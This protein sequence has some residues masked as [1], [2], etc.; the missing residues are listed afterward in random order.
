VLFVA[1]CAV[2]VL[3]AA[4]PVPAAPALPRPAHVV[5]IIEENHTEAS[6]IGNADARYMNALAHQGALF[7]RSYAITHPSLPNYLALFSGR[8]NDNGDG[9]PATGLPHTAPSLGGELTAAGL[10]FTGYAEGLPAPGSMVCWAGNYAR[11]HAPWVH[12]TDIAQAQQSL[13]LTRFPQNFERLP[14]LA[15]LIPDQM[16]DMHDGTIAQAD[17]WLRK[18]VAPLVTWAQTHDTLVILTWDE[19][20]R[21]ADNR[22]PTIFLGSMVKPGAYSE[23]ITHYTVLRTLEDMYGLKHLGA[24]GG[25]TPIADV[26]R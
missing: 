5:V 9:C 11:K 23:H 17:A 16:D 12:F 7:T 24:S 3:A 14:T 1:G 26:W 25:V 10:T 21:S 19:D 6:I 20:D 2:V 8:T 4:R 15:Y 13:P 18:H 22:I